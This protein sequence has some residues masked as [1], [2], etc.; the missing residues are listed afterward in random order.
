MKDLNERVNGAEVLRAL[1]EAG[2]GYALYDE[3]GAS[4]MASQSIEATLELACA[5]DREEARARLGA[6]V[7]RALDGERVVDH[8]AFGDGEASRC[9]RLTAI[10]MEHAGVARVL[11]WVSDVSEAARAQ[12]KAQAQAARAARAE[13]AKDQFLATLSHEL[14]TPLA[15]ILGWTQLLKARSADASTIDNALATIDRAARSQLR[16]IDDI[17]VAARVVAGALRLERRPVDLGV[18]VAR[19]A[20]AV[21]ATA[22]G[23][24]VRIDLTLRDGCVVDGDAG[25]LE[26]VAFHLLANAVKFSARGGAVRVAVDRA[27]DSATLE[28]R[29]EGVGIVAELLPKVF[30]RFTQGETGL[31]RA[32]GGLGLGLSLARHLVEAH[33]GSIH[34]ASEGSGRGTTVL[35]RVPLAS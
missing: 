30:E 35:V 20:E 19:A 2:V 6:A 12:A 8:C 21:R 28:V 27:S 13:A 23:K 9:F 25:R 11:V 5:R 10:P 7:S 18:A 24:D 15:T 31:T 17:L 22:E 3:R 32:H 4:I 16:L 33:G 34:V 26:H 1:D 14:R 29:D